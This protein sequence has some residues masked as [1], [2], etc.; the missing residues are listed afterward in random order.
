M[1]VEDTGVSVVLVPYE[2]H[3]ARAVNRAYFR[4]SG[5]REAPLLQTAGFRM[6]LRDEGE[7]NHILKSIVDSA[8][9]TASFNLH[10]SE[11]ANSGILI[12]EFS[13]LAI[14]A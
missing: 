8:R 10:R 12:D 4:S 11:L 3:V 2:K 13:A 5:L 6:C 9:V 7:E 14:H 1:P